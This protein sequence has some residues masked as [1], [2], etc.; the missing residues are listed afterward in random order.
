V[1]EKCTSQ[2][3]Q[4]VLFICAFYYITQ[5]AHKWVAEQAGVKCRRSCNIDGAW[6]QTHGTHP[7]SS[8]LN[9]INTMWVLHLSHESHR[10]TARN[11]PFYYLIIALS[12]YDRYFIG[13]LFIIYAHCAN[14]RGW[15]CT[16]A[17][18]AVRAYSVSLSIL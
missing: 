18:T 7:C 12:I 1:W 2:I 13:G 10:S 5:A 11:D 15:D 4:R 16:H 9:G 8:K 6:W 14:W 17:F 3:E